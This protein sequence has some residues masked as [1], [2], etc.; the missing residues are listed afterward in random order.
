MGLFDVIAGNVKCPHCGKSTLFK[1]QTKS[2]YPYQNDYSKG[3]LLKGG[4]FMNK[5][6]HDQKHAISFWKV[7]PVT[8]V[9]LQ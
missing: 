3:S 2:L 8:E 6:Y 4:P 7:Y 5:E 9:G 1:C